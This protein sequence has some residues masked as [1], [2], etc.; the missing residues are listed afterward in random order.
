MVA[1]NGTVMHGLSLIYVLRD[2]PGVKSFK[3]VQESREWT[4]VLL[5]TEQGFTPEAAAL[6]VS[7]FK[8]RLGADVSVAVEL[9]DSIPAEKSGNAT[10]TDEPLRVIERP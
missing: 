7:G 6:I 1:A 4:R 9:V 3:V 2:L 8:Q 10:A 5:V